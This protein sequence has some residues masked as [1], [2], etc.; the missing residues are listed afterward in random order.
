[1]EITGSCYCGEI[2]YQ[3]KSQNN[4]ALV[5]HCSDCQRM[6]SGPFRA[7]KLQS[8]IRS[9]LP[10][11]RQKSLLRQRKAVTSVR[12]VFVVHV[13]QHFMQLTKL[14]LTV[15]MACVLVRLISVNSLRQG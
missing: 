5:C 4:N 11:V 13:V 2:K 1:M 14:K 9:C 8:Q 7:V 15:Y 12:K 6:S 10:K 3:A